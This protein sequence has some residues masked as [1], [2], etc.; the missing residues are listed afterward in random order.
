VPATEFFKNP[1]ALDAFSIA[2]TAASL[3]YNR[4]NT[5]EQHCNTLQYTATHSVPTLQH[6]ETHCNK[7]FDIF[8]VAATAASLA[9][10]RRNK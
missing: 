10:N 3:A 7:A 6:F 2:A 5:C 4:R 1:K 8:I 9:Y